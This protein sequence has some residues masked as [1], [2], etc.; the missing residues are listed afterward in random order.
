MGLL[1]SKL[2]MSLIFLFDI[3]ARESELKPNIGF[4]GLNGDCV[5][6]ARNMLCI[7]LFCGSLGGAGAAA[8]LFAVLFPQQVSESAVGLFKCAQLL[9]EKFF[10]PR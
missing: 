8:H 9:Q 4:N 10:L 5:S 3:A 6:S 2:H 1:D 7:Q